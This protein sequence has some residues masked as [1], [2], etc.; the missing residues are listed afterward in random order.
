[1]IRTLIFLILMNFLNVANASMGKDLE[2][3]FKAMGASSNATMPNA[4]KDQQGG[5]MS[6]GGIMVRGPVENTKLLS[7]TP[8]S[9][10]SGCGGI[11]LHFGGFSYLNSEQ[12]VRM[13]QK[14]GSNAQSFAFSIA[15][16]TVSPQIKSTIDQLMA[17][18]EDVNNMNINSCNAA[19]ALVG[20]VFPKSEASSKMLC[21][22][23]GMSSNYFTDWAAT[24]QG[25]QDPGK[26]NDVL[27]K[28]NEGDFK[29]QLGEE[30][31]LAWKAMKKNGMFANDDELAELFMSI[32]G[33]IISRKKDGTKD[34]VQV[35]HLPSLAKN[36]EWL[37]ALINGEVVGDNPKLF[38]VYKCKD[39][40]ENKC[41]APKEEQ[42]KILQGQSF[43][44]KVNQ[45]T[46]G[47]VKKVR[48]ESKL[49][50]TKK[51][52]GPTLENFEKGFINSTKVPI[53]KIISV[54]AAYNPNNLPIAI[55]EFN[56]VIA[57]DLV[58]NYL[59]R[60][61]DIVEESARELE[62]I[63]INDNH[64]NNFFLNLNRTK[65]LIFKRR[66]GLFRHLNEMLA[67]IERTQ[68]IEKQLYS[69]FVEGEK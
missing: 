64:L 12:L 51:E 63:Q 53:L 60:V 54:Q 19:A 10:K 5:Y 35:Y 61:V 26:K 33:S 42:V 3:F 25:C 4:Y 28:K 39:K 56:E 66:Q 31:N 43:L 15:L 18:A 37:K 69:L 20:G 58:L 23:I 16:Q 48:D 6:G 27:N 67:A 2:G 11:D 1:M 44:E 14:I 50:G 65:S 45:I 34:K 47:I 36:E 7:L 38:S 52:G 62:S 32:S 68:Q 29:D 21:S 57:Y 40:D 8:P 24:R 46:A 30:F 41:L 22:H 17:L 55:S 9:F 59:D 13:L 49:T